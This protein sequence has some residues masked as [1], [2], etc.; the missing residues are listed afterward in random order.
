M[1]GCTVKWG[2]ELEVLDIHIRPVIEQPLHSVQ[3]SSIACVTQYRVFMIVT[4]ID[5]R[6]IPMQ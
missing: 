2:P 5:V 3:N 4:N 6:T 1:V